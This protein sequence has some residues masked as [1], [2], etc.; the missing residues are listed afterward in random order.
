MRNQRTSFISKV[1][2]IT[3]FT[4]TF[5]L[6]GLGEEKGWAKVGSY[7]LQGSERFISQFFEDE[8]PTITVLRPATISLSDKPLRTEPPLGL[9]QKKRL[10]VLLFFLC[11]ASEDEV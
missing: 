3:V 2:G 5:G 4:A 1:I 10:G 11:V 6:S 9:P 8:E 7:N